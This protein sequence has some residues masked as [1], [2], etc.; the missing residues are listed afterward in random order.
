MSDHNLRYFGLAALTGLTALGWVL[1]KLT[2]EITAAV[3]IAL[4]G[5]VG[6]DMYKARKVTE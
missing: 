5:L 3:F 6:L 2:P 1:D 4:G